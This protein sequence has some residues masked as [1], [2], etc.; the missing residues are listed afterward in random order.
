MTKNDWIAINFCLLAVLIDFEDKV[1][2]AQMLYEVKQTESL[3]YTKLV[4]YDVLSSDEHERV[5]SRIFMDEI[6]ALVTEESM[7]YQNMFF[8][9]SPIVSCFFYVPFT[10]EFSQTFKTFIRSGLN[11]CFELDSVWPIQQSKG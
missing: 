10:A 8:A 7:L 5:Y 3:K 1:K 11:G 6:Q 2:L 9:V 4:Q